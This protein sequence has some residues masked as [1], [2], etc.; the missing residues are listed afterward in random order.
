MDYNLRSDC[1]NTTAREMQNSSQNQ[2]TVSN[3]ASY[4]FGQGAHP[5]MDGSS[6]AHRD[7]QVYDLAPYKTLFAIS[8]ALGI[9]AFKEAMDAHAAKEAREPTED[10]MNHMVDDLR[11]QYLNTFGREMY[12]QAVSPEEREA[13]ERRRNP[14]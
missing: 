13:T 14:R 12:E 6:P 10:E 9:A 2:S 3:T 1:C 4:I 5:I 7:F 8:P 11:M